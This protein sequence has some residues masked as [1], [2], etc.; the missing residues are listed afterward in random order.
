MKRGW[1][2]VLIASV[3]ALVIAV[4]LLPALG[5][6]D[7]L[8]LSRLR[9]V[10]MVYYELIDARLGPEERIA[11]GPYDDANNQ[12][13]WDPTT[14]GVLRWYRPDG[15]REYLVSD[16]PDVPHVD[17][18]A[19]RDR[20]GVWLVEPGWGT[21]A[22][23]DRQTEEVLDANGLVMDWRLSL[24]AQGRQDAEQKEYP[25]WATPTGGVLLAEWPQ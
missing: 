16:S 18:R 11:F 12:T 9:P 5:G 2:G 8:R 20:R 10:D 17:I 21:V 6:P 4:A 3:V 22:S 24:K 19:T 23:L 7:V 15:M 1:V 13:W 25:A 14:V